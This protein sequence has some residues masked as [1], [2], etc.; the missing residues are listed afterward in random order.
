MTFSIENR[1]DIIVMEHYQARFIL[2]GSQ[3]L[4]CL[5]DP[6]IQYF[7]TMLPQ[8]LRHPL[9]ITVCLISE[10]KGMLHLQNILMVI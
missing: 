9:W 2:P 3:L 1:T 7:K 8:L 10:H 5:V 6:Q 4:A